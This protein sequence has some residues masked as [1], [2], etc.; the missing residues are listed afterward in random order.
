MLIWT[1][2]TVMTGGAVLALLWPL[3][4][5][6]GESFIDVA[7]A[8]SL[9][10]AQIAEIERDVRR[11]LLGDGEAQAARNEAARRLLKQG[12][13]SAIQPDGETE[14][15]LRRRRAASAIILSCVPLLA[16]LLYGAHGSPAAP[17]LPL[18][19]RIQETPADQDFALAMARIEKHLAANPTDGK[20]WS[21]LAPVY[22]RQ[23]R[24]HDAARAFAAAIRSG[25]TGAEMHAGLGESQTLSA[26]G[27]VTVEARESFAKAV[28]VDPANVRS[29]FFLAIAREQDGD[30]AG[31]AEGLRA[32]LKEAPA[33]ASWRE[34]VRQRLERLDPQAATRQAI[35]ELPAE[36]R[37]AAI[38]SMVDGLAARLKDGGG[39]L[40]E[41]SR[42][43]RS[44]LVLGE[45]RAAS[46]AIATARQRLAQ[47]PG[48]GDQLDRLA[49]ELQKAGG[50]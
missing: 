5:R 42:L 23:G 28:E 33:G 2:F 10:R 9:Y 7:D 29:R 38:R 31:A 6:G 20:G 18:A 21:V 48:A 50:P 12:N 22:L 25:V 30:A 4:R 27:V 14:H 49:D 35:A 19:A 1:I 46:E 3:G 44:Q 8:A 16:L 32:L 13:V 40:A 34:M 11:G 39:D 36:Q 43:I 45:R 24:S 41:W 17:D 47:V 26:G 15:S 37:N